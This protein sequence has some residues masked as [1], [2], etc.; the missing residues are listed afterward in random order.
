MFGEAEPGRVVNLEV[1][2][3]AKHVEKPLVGAR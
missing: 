2:M 3:L 1:D